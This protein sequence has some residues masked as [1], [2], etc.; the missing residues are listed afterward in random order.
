M[1][2][3]VINATIQSLP[4][5]LLKR[6]MMA[7]KMTLAQRRQHYDD[8]LASGMCKSAY[9]RL[10]GINHKTFWHLCR[11]LSADVSAAPAPANHKPPLLPVTLT[12]N[13]TA[14]LKLHRASVTS[15]PAAIA[16][17]IRELN[18]C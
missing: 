10:H 18:L 12:V 13:D 17:I 14:I 1:L 8:W 11:Q 2:L 3:V 7:K 4:N 5:L 6:E 15:T 9:A 16:A